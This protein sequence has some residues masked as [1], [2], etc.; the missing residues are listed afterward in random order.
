MLTNYYFNVTLSKSFRFEK[1]CNWPR[2]LRAP[3]VLACAMRSLAIV[4]TIVQS[5]FFFYSRLGLRA[6]C[7]LAC[8]MRSLAIVI[9][10]VQ[11]LLFFL[12]AI[13]SLVVTF[14][15]TQSVSHLFAN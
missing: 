15:L 11:S 2:R 8:A 3:C 7:V 12:E 4:I 13:A 5:F 1:T 10:I 6:P 9:T 14:S